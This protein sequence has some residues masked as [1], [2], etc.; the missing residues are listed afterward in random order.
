MFAADF[1]R[2]PETI[3]LM[4]QTPARPLLITDCDEVLLHMVSPFRD[5]LDAEKNVDFHFARADF[6]QALVDRDSGKTVEQ[7]EIWALLNGF[8]DTQMDRQTPIH[9][10][11]EAMQRISEIADVV[12]L[13]NLLDHRRDNRAAQLR[14]FGLDFPV[15]TNQG[16]KGV[17]LATIVAEYAPSVAL[18]IDDLPQHHESVAKHAPQCWRLHM[19]GEI[20]IA[21]HIACAEEAGHAHARI[22]RWSEALP[23]IVETFERGEPAP[24]EESVPA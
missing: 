9:G 23:W 13:T 18:F 7:S 12:V 14:Q 22:D 6:S 2:G 1:D 16:G 19:V 20:E 4:M 15:V 11:L 5:W 24:Y 10:A 21:P 17:A 8:F 3:G